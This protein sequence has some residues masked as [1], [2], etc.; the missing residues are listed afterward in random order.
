MVCFFDG[1]CRGNQFSRKG[2]MWVAYVLGDEEHV[3]E[4][5]D[6]A[7]P[8]GPQRTSNIAE[9]QALILLLGRLR[10]L[11]HDGRPERVEVCGDSQLVVYQMLGRY[12][13]RDAKLQPLHQEAKRLAAGLPITFRWIPREKN[14][15]G[16]LL[17]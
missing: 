16:H 3:H 7:T 2:P 15:A 11:R 4:I 8:R 5:P 17:E 6:L 10:E 13:V 14:R 12:R 9:Y 1:A